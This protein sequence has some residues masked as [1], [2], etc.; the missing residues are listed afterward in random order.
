MGCVEKAALA[1]YPD[2]VV[3]VV[4]DHGFVRTDYRVNLMVPFVK[5][6][7]I[8]DPGSHASGWK[9]SIF[10][11]GGTAAIVLHDRNDKATEEA[12]RKLLHELAANPANGIAAILEKPE[13]EKLGGFPNATFV[14]DLQTRLSAW[15]RHPGRA[16]NSRAF[17]RNARLSPHRTRRCAP[18][19]SCAAKASPR[20][21][22]SA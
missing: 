10:P 2:A 21:A 1:A 13:I 4:S 16:D 18:H 11:G 9:A 6:G 8:R 20:D 12:V 15:L 3:A 22:T 7:L 5:A 17:H 19:C 14:V